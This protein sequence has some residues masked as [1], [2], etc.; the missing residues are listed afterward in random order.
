MKYLVLQKSFPIV[1]TTEQHGQH[2]FDINCRRCCSSDPK[3]TADNERPR[4]NTE[5]APSEKAPSGT[6]LTLVSSL[7]PFRIGKKALKNESQSFRATDSGG[8]VRDVVS[9]PL[10]RLDS[11]NRSHLKQQGKPEASR[12]YR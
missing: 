12:H 1:D 8:K 3:A 9:S 5:K 10:R 7:P 2:V 6:T 4:D 11:E